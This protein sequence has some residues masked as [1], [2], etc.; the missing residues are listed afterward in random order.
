MT[1]RS[2]LTDF[3][4]QGREWMRLPCAA[5]LEK[6][7]DDRDFETYS[8]SLLDVLVLGIVGVASAVAFAA[9]VD[10]SSYA[11]GPSEP[12]LRQMTRTILW[13]Q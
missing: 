9:S 2:H 12:F 5:C 6:S 13:P 1:L 7:G 3:Q 10:S 4:N 11:S 8:G